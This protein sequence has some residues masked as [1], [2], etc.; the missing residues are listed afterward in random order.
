M[1]EVG[2]ELFPVFCYCRLITVCILYINYMIIY[3]KMY[4]YNCKLYDEN[5]NLISFIFQMK[6]Q[7][8]LE[9]FIECLK[10][11]KPNKWEDLYNAF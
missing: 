8:E 3:G 5:I 9:H 1:V 6:K 7:L 2:G 11:Q 10:P 4:L